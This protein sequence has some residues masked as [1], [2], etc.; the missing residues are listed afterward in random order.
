[1]A[2]LGFRSIQEMVGRVDK[3]EMRNAIDHWKAKGLDYSK[4]LYR[5]N[6]DEEV[7][8]YCQMKQDHVLEKSLDMTKILEAGKPSDRGRQ[9]G[10]DQL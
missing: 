10:R 8:T 4:I 6:V 3:L 7:G 9:S 1:M 2:K 5:P